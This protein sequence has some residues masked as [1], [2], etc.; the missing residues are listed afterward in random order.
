MPAARL[1]Q[2]AKEL[3][4]EQ[5][6]LFNQSRKLTKPELLDYFLRH[7]QIMEIYS[8]MDYIAAERFRLLGDA[9]SLR[10]DWHDAT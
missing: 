8:K 3:V 10:N 6:N 4:L 2:E 7:Q 9:A 5:I 1:K